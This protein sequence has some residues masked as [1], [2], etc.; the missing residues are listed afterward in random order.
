[1]A[2]KANI[3]ALV[4]EMRR[5]CSPV[6]KQS[7]SWSVIPT[8]RSHL[9]YQI[10][11]EPNY[12]LVIIFLFSVP[13]SN[14]HQLKILSSCRLPCHQNQLHSLMT[15]E[16]ENRPGLDATLMVS[17]TLIKCFSN[18]IHFW[19]WVEVCFYASPPPS[20]NKLQKDS[21]LQC[22]LLG[23]WLIPCNRDKCFQCKPNC[24]SRLNWQM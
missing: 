6:A 13:S 9:S 7:D 23:R 14:V 20:Q 4:S 21:P 18:L 22:P 1:M 8:L 12:N 2:T 15:S 19:C 24:P 10:P 11:P 3:G 16:N 17:S 5:Q